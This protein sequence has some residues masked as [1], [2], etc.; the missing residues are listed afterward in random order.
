MLVHLSPLEKKNMFIV[1][2]NRVA[3]QKRGKE[4]KQ[5]FNTNI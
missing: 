4:S 1:D 2:T 3:V 5:D